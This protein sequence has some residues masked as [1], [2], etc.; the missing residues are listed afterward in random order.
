M[1]SIIDGSVSEVVAFSDNPKNAG[2]KP[3]LIIPCGKNNQFADLFEG[4]GGRLN[5]F[6]SDGFIKILPVID[7]SE[8][9]HFA[10]LRTNLNELLS[11]SAWQKFLAKNYISELPDLNHFL[12][13]KVI[14]VAAKDSKGNPQLNHTN[15][16]EIY[17]EIK[18][19]IG[20]RAQFSISLVLLGKPESDPKAYQ[21]Y[22]PRIFLTT[23]GMGGVKFKQEDI[24]QA[25][26]NILVE[27]ATSNVTEKLK[28]IVNMEYPANNWITAGCSTI[29]ANSFEA[30]EIFRSEVLYSFIKP[31]DK[32]SLT[33]VECK[34]LDVL[35]EDVVNKFQ[36][37]LFRNGGVGEK[38]EFGVT[39]IVNNLGWIMGTEGINIKSCSIKKTSELSS[40]I[41]NKNKKFILNE[42]AILL[43]S[44]G[45]FI[46]KLGIWIKNSAIRLGR[47]FSQISLSTNENIKPL[48]LANY[49]TVNSILSVELSR[50]VKSGIG[51]MLTLFAFLLDRDG[52][53]SMLGS[54]PFEPQRITVSGLPVLTHALSKT[55]DVLSNVV[56]VKLSGK[57]INPI[58][59]SSDEFFDAASEEDSTRIN[60]E[61]RKFERFNKNIVPWYFG[62]I[63]MVV[64]W[65]LLFWLFDSIFTIKTQV[66]MLISAGLLLSTSLVEFIIWRLRCKNVLDEVGKEINLIL[67]KRIV[68][69]IA[70]RLLNYRLLTIVHLKKLLITFGD[71]EKTIQEMLKDVD[72]YRLEHSI[73]K[74]DR[75]DETL[76]SLSIAKRILGKETLLVKDEYA[77]EWPSLE[78]E[79]ASIWIDEENRTTYLGWKS[80]A[81]KLANVE[82]LRENDHLHKVETQLVAKYLLPLLRTSTSTMN[83]NKVFM[84][85]ADY[86][87]NEVYRPDLLNINLL[88][89]EN[90]SLGD[91]KKW[92]W[93]YQHAHPMGAGDLKYKSLQSFTLVFVPNNDVLIGLTGKNNEYWKT[94]WKVINSR[95]NELSCLRCIVTNN[96]EE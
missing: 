33:E 91:G 10:G 85:K 53:S 90:M 30:F 94:D 3:T 63:K 38:I 88:V 9:D 34:P 71:I 68:S 16:E 20:D 24:L 92:N 1:T 42:D 57:K 36:V 25:C 39:E 84:E 93:L 8:T 76:Y 80:E 75:E 4:L 29:N 37:S 89:D 27:L 44:D 17:S 61:V 65:P 47:L 21:H 78:G 96:F 83:L 59:L 56:D 95:I 40:I 19:R 31:L 67:T 74:T 55:I 49:K 87:A 22:W 70:T 2:L 54:I 35:I 52:S 12:Q 86:W 23:D 73:V 41:L 79:Y 82:A 7:F 60:N 64:S 32:P 6:V 5:R 28:E 15:V 26:Q 51:E 14:V 58:E 72:A 50:R 48:L 13:I 81:R 43:K 45:P 18:N 77:L 62:L 11:Q 46:K 66:S 69:I